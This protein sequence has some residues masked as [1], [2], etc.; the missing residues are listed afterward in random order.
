MTKRS[1][2]KENLKKKKIQNRRSVNM[3][4]KNNTKKFKTKDEEIDFL[5]DEVGRLKKQLKVAKKKINHMK[6]TSEDDT[7][8]GSKRKR[9]EKA[10]NR[11][12]SDSKKIKER[13]EQIKNP[14][15]HQDRNSV[16]T[17]SQY[18]KHHK[19]KK[20]EEVKENPEN[21]EQFKDSGLGFMD[22]DVKKVG[23]VFGVGLD[24]LALVDK[25]PPI[26]TQLVEAI[27]ENG[28]DKEGILR[29]SGSNEDINHYKILID[30]GK[31]VN[32]IDVDVHVVTGLL[33]S[34]FRQLPSSFIP[35][36][37]DAQIPLIIAQHRQGNKTEDIVLSELKDVIDNLIEPNLS[38]FRY[39][40]LFL[41]KIEA[42][43][44]ENKMTLDNIIKCFVP[45]VGCSPA[46]FYYAIK[47]CD[48]F[49]GKEQTIQ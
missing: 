41:T 24:K 26:I 8:R 35:Q 18:G 5:K 34:F 45:S 16:A 29:L 22:S 21:P 23:L 19:K 1:R 28:I 30:S 44:E 46:L 4:N 49:F 32:F 39:L 3:K 42:K 10:L 43:S 2:R 36:L 14:N 12:N 48:Y 9:Q 20:M 27:I 40:V 13:K 11:F 37:Y 17:P 33:K 38:I 25:I 6:S 15:K 31:K 47:H 7:M